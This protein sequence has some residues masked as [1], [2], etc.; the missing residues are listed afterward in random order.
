MVLPEEITKKGNEVIAK[1]V[2]TS[3]INL[4]KLI[5]GLSVNRPNLSNAIAIQDIVKR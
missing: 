1:Y 4:N 2:V 5:D 3:T